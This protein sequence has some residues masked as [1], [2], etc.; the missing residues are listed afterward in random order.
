MLHPQGRVVV[1]RSVV[2]ESDRPKSVLG[3]PRT[4][5]VTL[6]KLVKV[7]GPQLPHPHCGYSSIHLAGPFW[8]L[9]AMTL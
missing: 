3:E 9:K 5:C 8:G 7:S 1:V 6:G 4:G 2:S